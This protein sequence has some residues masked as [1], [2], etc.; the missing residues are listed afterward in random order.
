MTD[1][2]WGAAFIDSRMACARGLSPLNLPGAESLRSRCETI[3]ELESA[4]LTRPM[5]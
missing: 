1:V 3:R 2:R 5:R 4:D